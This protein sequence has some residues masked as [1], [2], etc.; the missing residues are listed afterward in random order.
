MRIMVV[1]VCYNVEINKIEYLKKLNDVDVYLYDNS[2]E[3][4][5]LS[6]EHW[7]YT[8]N[9]LNPGVSKAYNDAY[10][11]ALDM[12]VT[13]LLLLD[14]DTAFSEEILDKYREAARKYGDQYLVAPIIH[15]ND[16]VYSPFIEK[17]IRNRP[18]PL[19]EFNYMEQ[20]SLKGKSLINSGLLVPMKVFEE[21]GGFCEDIPLDFSDIYFMDQYK[22]RKDEIVLLKVK[23][24]HKLSGDEGY[25]EERELKRFRYYCRGAK[26][27]GRKIPE[28]KSKAFRFVVFRTIRLSMKYRTLKPLR[29]FMMYYAGEHKI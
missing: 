29:T 12:G 23:L 21:T 5:K 2:P 3:P 4:Q 10:E 8:H 25:D 19:N 16:K 9:P 17:F 6:N 24:E 22:K 26:V 27:Y 15:G 18:M 11:K 28:K 14:H 1:V 7:M 20:Y 13:H